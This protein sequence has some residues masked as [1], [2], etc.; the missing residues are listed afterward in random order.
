MVI[1]DSISDGNGDRGYISDH[2]VR[3]ENGCRKILSADGATYYEGPADG[4][5]WVKYFRDYLLTYTAVETVDNNAIGGKSAKWGNA[6]REGWISQEYDAIFVMLGTNDRWDCLNPEEF[7]TEYAQ[8]LAYAA[9]RCS[10][11]TVLTP[12]PA[13]TSY[14]DPKP[15]DTRQI[16]DTVLDLCANN[17]YP[18]INLYLG[19]MQ[20][21]MLEGRPLDEY[22]LGGTHPNPTGYLALWRLIANELGLNLDIGDLYDKTSVSEVYDIGVNR[23]DISEHTPLTAES[24]GHAVFPIGIS[25]YC[26]TDVFQADVKYGGTIVTYRYASGGGYQI[27][28]PFYYGYDF[29]RYAGA[30]G[31]W[32]EWSITNRDQFYKED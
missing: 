4:Q 17:G 31:S 15:M 14:E 5:G 25:I 11:L 27:F 32:G 3:A 26:T 20:Y 30:D 21:A 1:G 2:Q 13:F 19:L 24:A 7:Y 6:H 8:L 12:I 23:G 28:K 29:I 16:A 9:S 18:C 22:F 10:Y